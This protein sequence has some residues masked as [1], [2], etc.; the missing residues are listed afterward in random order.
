M[1]YYKATLFNVGPPIDMEDTT[2]VYCE[3][4]DPGE[5]LIVA[6]DTHGKPVKTYEE[7]SKDVYDANK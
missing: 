1:K 7:V 3:A 2:V 5:L 4:P 6:L